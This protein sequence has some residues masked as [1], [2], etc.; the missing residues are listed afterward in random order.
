MHVPMILLL[1]CILG[2]YP[3]TFTKFQWQ[4]LC[5]CMQL[6]SW[7]SAH[8]DIIYKLHIN[9]KHK[10][11]YPWI[12][13]KWH[14]DINNN[15]IIVHCQVHL[16]IIVINACMIGTKAVLV[17]HHL[18]QT[19]LAIIAIILYPLYITRYI[20][21]LEISHTWNVN[22]AVHTHTHTHTLLY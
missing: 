7:V 22:Y 19:R 1:P 6:I 11:K 9:F 5:K 15:N 13:T 16:M 2:K 10:F 14:V 12:L 8:V 21:Y 3:M 20:S 4:L 18:N 17:Y